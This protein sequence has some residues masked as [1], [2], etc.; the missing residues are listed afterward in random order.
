MNIRLEN[1]VRERV[2]YFLQNE[3]SSIGWWDGEDDKNLKELGLVDDGYEEFL[4]EVQKIADKLHWAMERGL[5]D[6]E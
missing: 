4:K 2:E 3:I 1:A 5:K 6:N